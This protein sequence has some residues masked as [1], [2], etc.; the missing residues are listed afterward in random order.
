L[1]KEGLI[2]RVQKKGT[3]KKYSKK[4]LEQKKKGRKRGTGKKKGKKGAKNP[5][6]KIWMNKIR[7][8][9]DMLKELRDNKKITKSDY[10]TLY[11]RAKGG[12]FRNKKHLLYYMKDH[13]IL[14]E[15]KK[16]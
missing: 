14:K 10:R 3:S 16:K 9:R 6:K 1:I 11:L 8:I 13:G 2:H 12:M 7:P 15:K 4:L 5:G